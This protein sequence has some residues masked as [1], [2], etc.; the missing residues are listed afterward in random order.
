LIIQGHPSLPFSGD[1][2]DPGPLSTRDAAQVFLAYAPALVDDDRRFDLIDYAGGVPRAVELIAKV[3]TRCDLGDL[4]TYRRIDRMKEGHGD[5]RQSSLSR[6]IELVLSTPVIGADERRLLQR[7]ELFPAGIAPDDSSTLF[8]DVPLARLALGRLYEVGLLRSF[9]AGVG[10]VPVV[11]AYLEESPEAAE[12]PIATRRSF[13]EL[14]TLRAGQDDQASGPWLVSNGPNVERACREQ[15]PG[16]DRLAVAAIAHVGYWLVTP[17]VADAAVA[18]GDEGLAVALVAAATEADRAVQWTTVLVLLLVARRIRHRLGDH[19]GEANALYQLGNLA[20][21]HSRWDEAQTYVNAALTLYRDIGERVGE[22]NALRELGNLA[23]LH[24]RLDEAHTYVNDALTLYRG[25]GERL[26]E[27][28]ARYELG[29][30]AARRGKWDEARNYLDDALI[31]YRDIPDRLGEA[32]ARCE[33]GRV[34]LQL[35][36]LDGA[37]LQLYNARVLYSA[38]GESAPWLDPDLERLQLA[39]HRVKE[40]EERGS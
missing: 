9:G 31:R 14:A 34:A 32:N 3:S 7:L 19:L 17:A 36:D 39:R 37:D 33:L 25:I 30:V 11:A 27:A 15:W 5:S 2:V 18:A 8:P 28:N 24:S 38:I 22:A 12:D 35:G 13:V 26:G 4:L 20:L 1:I 21:L 6:A 10:V 29:R 16:A 23:L 40:A